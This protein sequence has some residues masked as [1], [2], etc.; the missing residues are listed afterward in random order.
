MQK[1]IFVNLVFVLLVCP[2][3]YAAKK[4][5]KLESPNWEKLN[6]DSYLTENVQSREIKSLDPNKRGRNTYHIISSLNPTNGEKTLLMHLFDFDADGKIDLAKHFENGLVVR[7]EWNLDRDQ[8]VEAIKYHRGDKA[9]VYLKIENDGSRNI[10][11]HYFKGELRRQE[12]DRNQDGKADMWYYFRGGK[13][14]RAQAA[15]DFDPKK[16][17]D[18]TK[19]VTN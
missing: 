5:D 2:Y 7:S 10:W 1:S 15:K 19:S 13:L 8:K 18:I 17:E 4:S 14:F 16:I 12:F 6:L 9:E 11:S 3:S